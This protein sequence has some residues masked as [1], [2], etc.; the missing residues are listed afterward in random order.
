M[1]LSSNSL[2][3]WP[4]S[5]RI[6]IDQYFRRNLLAILI[7]PHGHAAVGIDAVDRTG[8]NLLLNGAVGRLTIKISLRDI[9]IEG[10]IAA[11]YHIHYSCILVSAPALAEAVTLAHGQ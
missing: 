9:V 10:G 4:K 1:R 11:D 6:G 5:Q 8:F 2:L 3:R 7:A